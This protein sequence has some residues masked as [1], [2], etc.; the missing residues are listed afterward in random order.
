MAIGYSMGFLSPPSDRFKTKSQI[1]DYVLNKFS[2]D[3][4]IQLFEELIQEMN[5]RKELRENAN[6]RTENQN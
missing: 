2:D 5:R 1:K 6:L 3:E 4:Q